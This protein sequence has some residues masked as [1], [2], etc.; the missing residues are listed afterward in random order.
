MSGRPRLE[1]LLARYVEEHVV[2]GRRPDLEF[3]CGGD[4][5]LTETLSGWIREYARIDEM[6][7][8]TDAP[9]E[10]EELPTFE[11]FRTIERVGVG[12][13]GEVYKLEDL[14]LG[15]TVAGKVV[16][17]DSPL[18]ANLDDFLREARSMALFSDPRIVTIHEFRGQA[19]P[20]VLLMEYVEGFELGTIG[21][22]LEYSQR[23]RLMLEVAEAIDHAHGLGVQHRDLKPSNIMLDA[24]LRP[25][26]LDFGLSR[27]EPDRGHGVGTLGYMAPEQLDPQ[28]S[29]DARSD[30][31]SLGVILYEL[32]CGARPYEAATTEELVRAI[33][34]SAPRLP[35]EIEPDAPEPLQAVALKAMERDP[36][37]RYGSARELALDLRRYLEG[38]PILARPTLY[39]SALE[40]RLRPHLEQ[41]R[42]WL[43]IKLIYPHEAERLH[44]AYAK[45]QAR[46]DDWIVQSRSLSFSQIALYLGAFLLVVG[47]LLYFY[48]YLLDAV[49]GLLAPTL[50]LG[51]PFVGLSVAAHLL[52]RRERQV[53]AVAFHLGAVLLLPLYLIIVFQELGLWVADPANEHELFGEGFTSNRQLRVASLTACLWSAWLARRTRTVALSACFTALLYL[54][55]VAVLADLGLRSWLEEG[56]WHRLSLHLTPLLALSVLL[57]RAM[58]SRRQPWLAQPLLYGG[59][60]LLVLILELLA[61]NGKAFEYLGLSMAPLQSPEVSDPLL[62]D[63]LTAMTLNGLLIY[64]T[65]WLL[66]RHGSRLMRETAWLLYV[67]SPFAILQPISYLNAVGEYSQR[68]DWIFLGLAL[69]I[70]FLSHFRQRKSFYY[71]GLLNTGAALWFITDHNDWF[72]RPAW[73]VVVALTGLA[74][75]LSGL[76]LHAGERNRS[77][78]L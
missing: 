5:E 35:V 77:G 24:R 49:A 36:A 71:A 47:S 42:E 48:A 17:R 45:L 15:R 41:I 72:D 59:A 58:E 22:S 43:R 52:Y 57:G 25:K 30:V 60:G 39:Q 6:L 13:G 75:L 67:I 26:I 16:R 69:L 50:V 44:S 68:Y 19:D 3:L 54:F 66:E 8:G 74:V 46:E 1:E 11:G 20:P 65:A 62:L 76:A 70:T 9:E 37:D 27:G 23:A 14:E 38:K 10:P 31:Y 33:R 7:G 73:A 34:S 40:R 55:S 21:R 32:I 61:L 56:D 2:H 63:T 12:G 53:V 4:P 64:G 28:R 51:L 29:I 18:R 78:P